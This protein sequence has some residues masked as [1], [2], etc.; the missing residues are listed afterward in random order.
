MGLDDSYSESNQG[1]SFTLDGF[2]TAAGQ[3]FQSTGGDIS[4]A[5]FYIKKYGSPTG[6]AYAKL[7]AHS[8][9][10]GTSSVPTGSALATSSA[11]D[12]STT[13]TSYVLYQLTFSTSYTMTASTY[14]VIVI[15]YTA[16][17]GVNF[18]EIGSDFTSP[19]HG[20]NACDYYSSAFHAYSSVDTCF[21]VYV[22]DA[23]ATVINI[24]DTW[25]T[26]DWTGSQINIGDVWKTITY[27]GINIGDVWK[28]VYGTP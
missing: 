8:G 9:T 4:S 26:I 12:V 13:T 28:T 17:D 3:S 2:T 20:G 15:E 11:L 10:F 5:K 27:V 19:T 23:A 24:G 22:A 25:K 6:S 14:Y 18:L 1:T 21:Y 16:G 7:Y